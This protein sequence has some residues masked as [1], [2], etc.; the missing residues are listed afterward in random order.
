MYYESLIK[1]LD[2]F[3]KEQEIRANEDG[4]FSGKDKTIKIEYNQ[5]SKCYELFTADEGGEF[6]KISSYLFDESQK[7]SDIESVAIDFADSLR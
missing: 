6:A 5:N 1:F 4:T 3:F 2:S 7:E